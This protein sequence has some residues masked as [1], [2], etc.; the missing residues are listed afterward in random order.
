[1]PADQVVG[2]G[3]AKDKAAGVSQSIKEGL[4]RP[5]AVVAL[6][7]WGA[8]AFIG[9]CFSI[10]LD[11]LGFYFLVAVNV[12]VVVGAYLLNP[13]LGGITLVVVVVGWLL[14][15]LLNLTVAVIDLVR[16]VRKVSKKQ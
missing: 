1:M 9:V 15:G 3:E 13:T 4:P 11:I 16:S 12:A 6:I 8:L 10:L 5:L 2:P 14:W 7:L